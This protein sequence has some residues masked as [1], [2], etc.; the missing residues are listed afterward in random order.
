MSVFNTGFPS[1]RKIQS[2]IK[3]KQTVEISLSNNVT[4]KGKILWQDPNCICL[5]ETEGE[6]TLIYFDA[7]V[8]VKPTN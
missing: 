2:F 6:Q 4:L 8:Y 5:T 7:I 1:V 3:E